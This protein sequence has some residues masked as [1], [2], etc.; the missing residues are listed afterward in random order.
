MRISKQGLLGQLNKCLNL[1]QIVP[2]LKSL[3]GN[4]FQSKVQ[5]TMKF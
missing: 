3:V 1:T 4:K 2:K 5:K